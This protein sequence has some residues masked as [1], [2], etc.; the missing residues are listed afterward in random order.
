M[1]LENAKG[2][3]V[4]I[5]ASEIMTS[6]PDEIGSV[7]ESI[8]DLNEGRIFYGMVEDPSL[9]DD[10]EITVIATGLTVDERPVWY[11]VQQVRLHHK[12]MCN[13]T[14]KYRNIKISTRQSIK[15]NSLE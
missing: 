12:S 6:E 13:P 1:R 11:S 15:K 9:G 5:S 10:I 4:N 2:L 14:N 8:I 7:L 3:L